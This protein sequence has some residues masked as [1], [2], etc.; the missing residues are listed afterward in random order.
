[1]S[2]S[3]LLAEIYVE[4]HRCDSQVPKFRSL[5]EACAVIAEEMDEVWDICRQKRRERN[6]DELRKEL[7]QVAAMAVK[8]I[9]SM[10]NLV[11]E[12]L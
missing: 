1:M 8:A 3:D 2:P 9:E 7:I 10:E 5:H 4:A 11:G 12:G 6:A